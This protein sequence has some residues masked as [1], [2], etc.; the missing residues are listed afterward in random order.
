MAGKE[1]IL[2]RH[3]AVMCML[4]LT[5]CLQHVGLFFHLWKPKLPA[6]VLKC[7]SP[8]FPFCQLGTLLHQLGWF[9]LDYYYFSLYQQ[10]LF[11]TLDVISTDVLATI[12]S[13]P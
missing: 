12:H 1:L 3:V 13:L 5:Y 11:I 2:I 7:H 6:Q 10:K 4:E 9:T 8:P